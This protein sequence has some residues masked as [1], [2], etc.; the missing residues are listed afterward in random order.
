MSFFP[1]SQNL[2]FETFSILPSNPKAWSHHLEK[3]PHFSFHIWAGSGHPL[4]TGVCVMWRPF[5][6]GRYGRRKAILCWKLTRLWASTLRSEIHRTFLNPRTVS[7]LYL[8][9]RATFLA[10]S[11]SNSP[12]E[13]RKV[14]L[15]TFESRNSEKGSPDCLIKSVCWTFPHFS[16]ILFEQNER[17]ES[18][19]KFSNSGKMRNVL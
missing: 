13:K 16:Y 8:V 18:E 11:N 14:F 2:S 19:K 12:N 15:Y 9:P 4:G 1:S 5:E 7:P 6:N 3:S 10:I 17:M